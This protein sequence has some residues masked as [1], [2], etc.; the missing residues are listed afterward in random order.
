MR[1]NSGGEPLEV[2]RS[3]RQ[4]GLDPHVLQTATHRPPQSVPT[5]RFPVITLRAPHMTAPQPALLRAP[6]RMAPTRAQ[7]RGIR[8]GNQHRPCS[9]ATS[10]DNPPGAGSPRKSPRLRNIPPPPL[11]RPTGGQLLPAWTLHDVVPRVVAEPAHRNT[12]LRGLPLRRYH[13]GDAPPLQR[14]INLRI[15]IPRIRRHQRGLTAREFVDRIQLGFH[16]LPLVQRPLRHRH[17]E[18]HTPLIVHHRVVLVARL[19]P[20]AAAP[21]RK[22]RVGGP[23]GSPAPNP[24]HRGRRHSSPPHPPSRSPAPHPPRDAPPGSP[25]SRPPGINEAST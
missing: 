14:P 8:L 6:P 13:P 23:Y 9:F 11:R 2:H 3:R 22:T 7:Q 18:N 5:L 10:P 25:S 19:E 4:V 16:H 17:V 1:C 21:A 12:A 20:R 24:H 15:R